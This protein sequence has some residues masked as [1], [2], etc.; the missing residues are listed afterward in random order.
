MNNFL[1]SDRRENVYPLKKRNENHY[2]NVHNKLNK[3]RGDFHDIQNGYR[4]IPTRKHR[5]REPFIQIS[6]DE[7]SQTNRNN[8]GNYVLDELAKKNENPIWYSVKRNKYGSG[9]YT[10]IW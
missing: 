6:S 4:G 1:L 2:T 8:P 5:G 10:K 3:N 9:F 7:Y